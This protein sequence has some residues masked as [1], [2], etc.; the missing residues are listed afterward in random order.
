MTAPDDFV[1]QAAK[2]VPHSANPEP[3]FATLINGLTEDL[4]RLF[5]LELALFRREMTGNLRRFGA[6]L[7]ALAVAAALALTAWLALCTAAVAALA[8]VW[9]VWLAALVVGAATVIPAGLLL[10]FGIRSIRVQGLVP[11]RTL[12]TL[13]EDGVWIRERVS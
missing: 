4:R 7:A 5:D 2:E 3:P 1:A 8:M 13:R 10:Y 6:G 12:G 9:P 11:R